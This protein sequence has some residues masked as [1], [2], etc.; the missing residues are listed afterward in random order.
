[1]SKVLQTYLFFFFLSFFAIK[2]PN[3]YKEEVN[4]T[5][6]SQIRVMFGPLNES[7]AKSFYFYMFVFWIITDVCRSWITQTLKV[8]PACKV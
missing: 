1:M 7:Q 3:L 2:T 8:M 6:A 4:I 5:L